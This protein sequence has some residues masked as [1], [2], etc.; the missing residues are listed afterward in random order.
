MNIGIVTTWFER[1]AA[2]VSRQFKDALS[3]QNNVFI[4]ARGGESYA[5]GDP[6]WDDANVFWSK[7]YVLPNPTF[8]EKNEFK[9]WLSDN[10]IELVIFNE[11]TWFEPVRICKELGVKTVAYVDYYKLNTIR[12]FDV[13]DSLICNTKRHADAFAKHP[14][15]AYIPWGTDVSTF[16]PSAKRDR[17]FIVFF[18][19]CGMAPYRKGTDLLLKAFYESDTLCSNSKLI[20]HTQVCLLKTTPDCKD[21]ISELIKK[22]CLEVIHKT[23]SAPGLYALGDVYVYPARLDGLGL[24]VAE[25]IASGLPTIVPNNPPMSEF[26]S[27]EC[28]VV[29][30]E[31][32]FSRDDGYYWPMCSVSLVDLR[33]KM[34]MFIDLDISSMSYKVREHAVDK[35]NWDMS[36]KKINEIIKLV[37]YR[38]V[39]DSLK[40]ETEMLDYSKFPY[41]SEFPNFYSFLYKRFKK[42][43][44]N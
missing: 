39:P 34:E 22:G 29:D 14:G 33:L 30:I 27:E 11:Q 42:R 23:V 24:T 3:A 16:K 35:L 32:Y 43:I 25:A 9:R 17:D 6:D 37:K 28:Q 26:S 31:K 15:M 4:Y 41:I 12:L 20:I 7:K 1:G 18:H 10:K 36:S 8:V 5:K 13:Y 19:S 21:I 38:S 2:Y 40:K 44:M